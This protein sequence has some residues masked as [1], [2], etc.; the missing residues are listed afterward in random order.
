MLTIN[1]LTYRIQGRELFEDAFLVLPDEEASLYTAAIDTV[2]AG[3]LGVIFK[4]L[5]PLNWVG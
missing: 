4:R 3:Y 1:S 2:F 5:F